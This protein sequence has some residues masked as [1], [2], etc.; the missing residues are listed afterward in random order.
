[1]RYVAIPTK[2]WVSETH[3][4]ESRP[5]CEVFESDPSPVDT[6]LLDPHGVKLFRIQDRVP[7]GFH[8]APKA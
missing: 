5:T 8:V 2:A 7:L 6:G 1:M 3:V 4:A